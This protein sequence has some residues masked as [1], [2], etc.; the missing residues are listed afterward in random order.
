MQT[1]LKKTVVA[2]LLAF[3]A[4]P[5][6]ASN[7][8]VVVPVPNRTATAAKDITVSLT[9]LSLPS[10]LIGTPYAGFDFKSL[11]NVTGDPA[12]NG[13]GVKWTVV[14]GSLPSGLTLNSNGTLSGTPMAAGTSSF[15][16]MAS[17]KSKAGQQAYQVQV[18]NI[19]VELASG[20]PPQA[21]VGQAYSY[22]LKPL[23]SVSGDNAYT[24]AG[25]TWTVVSSSLPAGLY[26]T[27]DGFI[28]GT[29][30]AGGTGSITA[31]ASYKGVNGQQ[32]YQVVSLAVSVTLAAGSPP[33]ALVGQ[34]YS[35]SLN[36][37]LS[38]NGDS[39]FNGAGVTWSVVS[40]TLP[41]GLYLTNDGWIGGT[42]TANGS[43]TITA[44][45]TYRGVN[46]QQT[47]QVVTL[48][49]A[50]GLAAGTPPQAIVGQAY[51]YSLSSLL[52]VTG[53]PAFSASDVNWSVVSNSLPQG[54]SMGADGTISG[55][56]TAGS[57]GSITAR[58]TYKG[59]DGQQTYQVVSLNIAVALAAATPPQAIVGQAYT[60]DLKSLLSVTGDAGYS[61]SNVTWTIDSG[62]L[63][64]G[65]TLGT[66]GVITGTPTAAGSGSIVARATYRGINGQQTYQVVTLN[67]AVGLASATATAATADDVYTYDLKP[68]LSVSGDSS[69]QV[70]AVTW[71]VSSGTLPTGLTLNSTTGVISGTPARSSTGTSNFAVTASYRSKTG[72]GTYTL[73]VAMAPAKPRWSVTTLALG[74]ASLSGTSNT[75]TA[76]LFNDGGL[77]GN[78]TALSNLGNGVTADA[79]G[80]S[81]VAPSA[82]CTVTFSFKPTVIGA[83]NLAGITPTASASRAVN[84]LAITAAGV[85]RVLA[86]NPAVSG[87]TSWNLDTDGPLRLAA[88][89]TYTVVPAT[90]M[91]ISTKLW[92][93]GGGG[94]GADA[95][96]FYSGVGGGAGYVGG[97]YVAAKSVSMTFNVGGAGGLGLSGVGSTGGGAGGWNGG[98]NG[99]NAGLTGS[100]GGGGGGGGLTELVVNG[101]EIACAGGGGGGG[102]DGNVATNG[103]NNGNYYGGWMT[104]KTGASGAQRSD[105]GGGPGGGGGGC[106]GGQASTYFPAFDSNAE[107]GA[108][109]ASVNY[110]LSGAVAAQPAMGGAPANSGDA[111]VGPNAH[112]GINAGA[113]GGAGTGSTGVAVLR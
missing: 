83:V 11:L 98:G 72:Q 10:G 105:D 32:S 38:V 95:T 70:S 49:I 39:A 1:L 61:A 29:P 40:S 109:G 23:L 64:A 24:G 58:A 54:L 7:Y 100:S 37:L 4:G 45:A 53:D 63:P 34:A 74:N 108:Y 68:L 28:G 93:G 94:G 52:T 47:Y 87:K 26:L 43:G 50:V 16:V 84:T 104:T 35:Y 57:T 9:G 55:T 62:T 15:Q 69:Y 27:S 99:G 59:V 31:R 106:N 89:G 20:A 8:F 67:V 80:C 110:G 12:Y 36:S 2:T 41:A 18:A 3:S 5:L 86:L 92:G 82:S 73:N 17:Y 113:S 65:L 75:G 90:S 48:N 112:G 85:Q 19:T 25:V 46:G 22:D 60:Y 71:T 44:R 77:A 107:G 78:W 81:N 96:P 88:A 56:P 101:S 76:T 66:S 51:S 97:T 103:N 111:D 6:L 30:T 33:Q 14:A 42:P 91:T 79:S 21:L 13:F 102:G